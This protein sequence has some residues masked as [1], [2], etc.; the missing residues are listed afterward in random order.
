MQR[1]AVGWIAVYGVKVVSL[2]LSMATFVVSM[3]NVLQQCHLFMNKCTLLA[4]LLS[5]KRI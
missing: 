4:I 5:A 3:E 2:N 1:S